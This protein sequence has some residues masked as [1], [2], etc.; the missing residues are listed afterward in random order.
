M[1]GGWSWEGG[2]GGS[3][4]GGGWS[5][6][7]G[8]AVAPTF[9]GGGVTRRKKKESSG[10]FGFVRN[11]AGDIESTLR[12]FPQGIATVARAAG[13]DIAH[14]VSLADIIRGE[15]ETRQKLVDPLGQAYAWQY[16]PLAHGDVG[17]FR[18]RLYE[19]P[20]GPI[21]DVA[22]LASGGAAAAG[23][24]GTVARAG[25][26]GRAAQTGR[27]LAPLRRYSASLER[28]RT[29]SFTPGEGVA[30]VT[31][32][33]RRARTPYGRALGR[34]VDTVGARHPT[35]RLVGNERRALRIRE[36]ERQ[37]QRS[38]TVANVR[39]F[40]RSTSPLN[41]DEKF[42]FH[43]AFEGRDPR[44][45][46]RDA[47]AVHDREPSQ[48]IQRYL[49]RLAAKPW[50]QI[51]EDVQA[52]RDPMRDSRV[53]AQVKNPSEP[54]VRAVAEGKRL[55]EAGG[56]VL[57]RAGVLTGEVR[58]ARRWLA[59][60]V[61]SGARYQDQDHI[62]ALTRQAEASA[63]QIETAI[64]KVERRIA[65][66]TDERE[67]AR[68]EA[69]REQLAAM[70]GRVHGSAE[71]LVNREPGLA[72]GTPIGELRAQREAELAGEAEG[73]VSPEFGLPSRFPHEATRERQNPLA[74]VEA[75]GTST[76][77]PGL[78]GSAKRNKGLRLLTTRLVTDPR[79]LS[80]DFLR[81][82][83]FQAVIDDWEWLRQFSRELDTRKGGSTDD[84]WVYFR[85]PGA[86]PP[87]REALEATPLMRDKFVADLEAGGRAIN[88]AEVERLAKDVVWGFDRNPTPSTSTREF[89]T[90]EEMNEAGI[91]QVP[92]RY[93]RAFMREHKKRN[94]LLRR[95]FDRPL[96]VWRAIVLTYRPAWLVN[97][98]VG[99]HLLYALNYAGPAGAGA[100]LRA[101]QLE[102]GDQPIRLLGRWTVAHK[103][104]SKWSRIVNEVYPGY[105]FGGFFRSQDFGSPTLFPS[106]SRLGRGVAAAHER[107]LR[108]APIRGAAV[109]IPLGAGALVRKF[110]DAMNWLNLHVADD[111]PRRAAFTLEAERSAAVKA[112]RR[113]ARLFDR[114]NVSLE[115]AIRQLDE[116][117]VNR[118]VDDVNRSLGNFAQLGYV[119]RNYIR[120]LVPFYSWFKTIAQITGR[121]ALDH[122]GRLRFLQLLDQ[123][124][125]DDPQIADLRDNM[126]T[127][128]RGAIPLS[129]VEGGNQTLLSTMAVNP[130][131][132]PLQLAEAGM[133][134][135][136]GLRRDPETG[137][138]DV[139]SR[140]TG[141]IF[142]MLNPLVG[143]LA[144]AQGT[145]LFYGGPYRGPFAGRGP[146][147]QG[148]GY[149]AGLPQL[150]LAEQVGAIGDYQSKLY[151]PT[152]RYGGVHP[153]ILNYLGI[154]VRRVRRAEAASRARAGQ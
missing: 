150:R 100:Y 70:L 68:L 105:S 84:G 114:A 123:L 22:A 69:R 98:I 87:S 78:P 60:R 73:A 44:A 5:W 32:E 67:L 147:A 30:P 47:L 137:E 12:G 153:A 104:R 113:Q 94:E 66:A 109:R 129:D 34:L 131:E 65:R 151:D 148:L 76:K 62:D 125:A 16:G 139:R 138:P 97:N 9:A 10:P 146:L 55:Q 135:A 136:P 95:F 108:E 92:E 145:D 107:P 72:G 144:A 18:H 17:E 140:G 117:T 88:E 43:L 21:L 1:P 119:E 52:G 11:L 101:L 132:T 133:S 42:A 99:Q 61:E 20:L 51:R 25:T 85:D 27:A 75:G 49:E 45:V 46:F 112:I 41:N 36:L 40:E 122:P 58:E 48:Q 141:S 128:L 33:V 134:L 59:Q 50:R 115:D 143:A 142:G 89:R 106:E 102:K 124:A 103:P 29:I 31:V 19:R 6:Q 79:I 96:D 54:L 2:G 35:L 116:P 152:Y 110:G 111:L 130:F 28:P 13:T 90:A 91:R 24:V 86:P 121:L 37:Q 74:V 63:K 26:L 7:G 80:R 23:R 83:G 120:R 127:Y 8:G 64:G 57:E 56:D 4:G 149:F 71:G 14:N 3:G 81:T 39:D 77:L 82:M 15:G 118:L 38:R 154:P 53:A 93:A 126:P